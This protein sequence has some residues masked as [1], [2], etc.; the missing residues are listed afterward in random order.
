MRTEITNREIAAGKSD[1]INWVNIARKTEANP[2]RKDMVG[3]LSLP[4]RTKYQD[5]GE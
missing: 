2:F 4:A 5:T 1:N 3:P